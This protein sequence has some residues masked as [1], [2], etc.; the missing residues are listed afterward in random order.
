MGEAGASG[1]KPWA[2]CGTEMFNNLP[3][4][5]QLGGGNPGSLALDHCSPLPLSTVR[6]SYWKKNKTNARFHP[7]KYRLN[8]L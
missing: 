3:K 2:L 1:M 5:T 4:V 8:Y 7:C 6:C